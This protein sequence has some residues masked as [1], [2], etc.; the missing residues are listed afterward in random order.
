MVPGTDGFFA[1]ADFVRG[2]LRAV[3]SRPGTNAVMIDA[4]TIPA[5]DVTAV[6][7]LIEVADE[8]RA[9]GVDLVLGP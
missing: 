2:H 8:Q 4:E 6:R 7:M 9:E 1:N 3:E 5:I